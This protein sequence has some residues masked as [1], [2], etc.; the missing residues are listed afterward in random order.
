MKNSTDISYRPVRNIRLS[1]GEIARILDVMDDAPV[2]SQ[3]TRRDSR[4]KYR[5]FE[6][7]VMIQQPG[8]SAP[9]IFIAPTRNISARGLSFLHGSFVHSGTAIVVQLLTT[10][11]G[12]QNVVATVR[13]CRYIQSNIHE[14][15]IQ[16]AHAIDP[17]L[18]SPDAV[19]SPPR[20]KGN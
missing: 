14:V 11:G 2:P 4:Y 6:I 3:T 13:R 20:G 7:V 1:A 15:A 8:N 5:Y 17:A 18:F 10:R 19:V 9:L 12:H 16:F